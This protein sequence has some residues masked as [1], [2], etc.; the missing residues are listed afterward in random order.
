MV[1]ERNENIDK[2]ILLTHGTDYP[3]EFKAK[4]SQLEENWGTDDVTGKQGPL[5]ELAKEKERRLKEYAKFDSTVYPIL[6]TALVIN[7]KWETAKKRIDRFCELF[8][9]LNTL[10]KLNAEIEKNT[11]I[12]FCKTFLQINAT[13]AQNPLSQLSELGLAGVAVLLK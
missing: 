10:Q 8:P 9:H 11:P 7:W 12:T 1:M 4:L 5:K 6:N 3:R 13:S 2:E